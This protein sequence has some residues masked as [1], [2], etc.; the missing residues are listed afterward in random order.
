M[1]AEQ[2]SSTQRE[3]GM[4]RAETIFIRSVIVILAFTALAKLISA[5][6]GARALEATDP[7]LMLTH[8]QVFLSVGIL[9][10]AI[11]AFLVFSSR[12]TLKVPVIAWLAGNFTVYRLGLY[13]IG[14]KLPCGCLGVL[15]EALGITPKTADLW[16]KGV[17]AYLLLGAAFFL[18]SRAARIG[19]VVENAS[20]AAARDIPCEPH[21]GRMV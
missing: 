13:W 1:K 5:S 7:L 2:Q 3:A 16:M 19:T 12:Q 8:R 9:E 11:A 18:V 10:L 17:L 4:R 6:G 15:T 14:A 21:T 20:A